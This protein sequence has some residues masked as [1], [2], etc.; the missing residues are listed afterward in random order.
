MKKVS[1]ELRDLV[2]LVPLEGLEPVSLPFGGAGERQEP[3]VLLG[4]LAPRDHCDQ[5]VLFQLK[6]KRSQKM[7]P[8]QW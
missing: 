6:S 1:R 8:A 3:S 4:F 5:A 7:D 2:F